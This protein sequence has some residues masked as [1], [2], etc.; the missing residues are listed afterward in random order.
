[1]RRVVCDRRRANAGASSA[2]NR[3]AGADSVD[4]RIAARQ[5]ELSPRPSPT[6]SINSEAA[7]LSTTQIQRRAS[8]T[9]ASTTSK[10]SGTGPREAANRALRHKVETEDTPP[11]QNGLVALQRCLSWS[12]VCTRPH[13]QC[14]RRD[15]HKLIHPTCSMEVSEAFYAGVAVGSWG[16]MCGGP[17]SVAEGGCG[18]SILGR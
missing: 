9:T 2:P 16:W 3:A 15:T 6:T 13:F 5:S 7:T 8:H 4:L 10:S 12:C 14:K 18:R 1:M 17:L 11:T